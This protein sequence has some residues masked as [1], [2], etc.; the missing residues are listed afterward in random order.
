MFAAFWSARSSARSARYAA[1]QAFISNEVNI[2]ERM[3]KAVEFLGSEKES[4][5]VGAILA[6]ERI[7]ADSPRDHHTIFEQL[8][9]F[10]KQRRFKKD[11]EIGAVERDILLALNVIGRRRLRKQSSQID[12]SQC[13]F[14]GIRLRYGFFENVNFFES[15]FDGASIFDC[16]FSESNLIRASFLGCIIK[17]SDF[18]KSKF[19]NSIL[20]NARFSDCILKRCDFTRTKVRSMTIG[21]SN[22]SGSKFV[23]NKFIKA[24]I[25]NVRLKNCI[26][27]SLTFED[28][29]IKNSILS[30]SIWNQCEISDS[31][32]RN[33][34]FS[35]SFFRKTK[36]LSAKL[37]GNSFKRSRLENLHAVNSSLLNSDLR[38]AKLILCTLPEVN[39]RGS[40]GRGLFIFK[41]PLS[42][43]QKISLNVPKFFPIDS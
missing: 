19:Q 15:N 24:E 3:S 34:N 42:Q 27:S 1:K 16:S 2:T 23:S 7:A 12:L 35:C 32:I 29:T 26:F 43:Q 10:V 5:R 30:K 38:K 21:A 41:T 28:S 33:S 9:G 25:F 37:Y 18:S 22:L 36:L 17:N 6:L 13:D 4:A 20:D 40:K 8:S 31:T 39:F 11:C 14:R